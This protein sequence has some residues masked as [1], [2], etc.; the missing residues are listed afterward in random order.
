MDK[1]ENLIAAMN[2]I[3]APPEVVAALKELAYTASETEIIPFKLHSDEALIT[4]IR[5]VFLAENYSKGVPSNL[6]M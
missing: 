4:M 5:L 3:Y 6:R 2:K 1:R